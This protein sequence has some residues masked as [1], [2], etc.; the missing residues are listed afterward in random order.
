MLGKVE[1]EPFEDS[2]QAAMPYID[3]LAPA[4]SLDSLKNSIN[5]ILQECC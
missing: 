5:Y 4:H 3:Q 2:M 1:Y